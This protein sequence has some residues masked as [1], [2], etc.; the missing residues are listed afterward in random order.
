M[1]LIRIRYSNAGFCA[2]DIFPAFLRELPAAAAHALSCAGMSLAPG[3]IAVEA[4]ASSPF[5]LN[6]AH[7]NL[8]VIAQDHPGRRERLDEI[9][10]EIEA[11]V[12]KHL[13][14]KTSW[15]VW[16]VLVHGSYGSGAQ[17]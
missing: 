11:V 9:R 13:P 4:D 3:D 10:A 5:D 17:S 1:P 2:K 16:V 12:Q 7:L 14:G 15:S 6:G 8:H